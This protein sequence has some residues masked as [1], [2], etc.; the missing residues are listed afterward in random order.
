MVSGILILK[1][2]ENS[3][4]SH[5]LFVIKTKK[6]NALKNHLYKNKIYTGIHYPLSLP[7]LPVFKQ[8]YYSQ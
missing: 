7:E 5:H 8:K 4:S 3:K 1:Q 6:R 2:T